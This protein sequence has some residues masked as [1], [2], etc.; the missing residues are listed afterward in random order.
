MER[1][2]QYICSDCGT[3]F[4]SPEILTEQIETRKGYISDECCPHCGSVNIECGLE[5]NLTFEWGGNN[6]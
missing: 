3:K 6:E 1:D 4:D 5:W 2:L